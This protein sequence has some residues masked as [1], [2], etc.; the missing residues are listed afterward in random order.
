MEKSKVSASLLLLFLPISI[1]KHNPP[2]CRQSAKPYCNLT[3]A[4]ERSRKT[5]KRK[6]SEREEEVE[7]ED[8]ETGP[9]WT[10]AC[11]RVFAQ[12]S[13]FGGHD[14]RP[15]FLLTESSDG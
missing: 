8:E 9:S 13:S 3:G 6:T 11:G 1:A 14:I 7:E 5:E 2:C 12:G 15:I 4:N 10:V